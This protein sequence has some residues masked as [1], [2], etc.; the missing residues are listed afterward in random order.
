MVV[1]LGCFFVTIL[2]LP[3]AL[4]VVAIEAALSIRLFLRAFIEAMLVPEAFN[5][6]T[7]AAGAG[8]LMAELFSLWS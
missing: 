6:A 5:D 4:A 7:T 3:Q 8:A 1:V 2:S